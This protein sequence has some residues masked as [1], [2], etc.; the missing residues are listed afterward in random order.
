MISQVGDDFGASSEAC[1]CLQRNNHFEFSKKDT[2][3]INNCQHYDETKTS[4]QS[5]DEMLNH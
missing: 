3:R 2:F 5:D 4:Y 1:D